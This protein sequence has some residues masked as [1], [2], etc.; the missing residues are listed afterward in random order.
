MTTAQETHE[1]APADPAVG[2]QLHRPV[3]RPVQKRAT[4]CEH[5]EPYFCGLCDAD[6]EQK[7]GRTCEHGNAWYCGWCGP[8]GVF[9]KIAAARA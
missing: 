5:G 9:A 7:A 8:L 6:A 4:L 2:I 3:G 1:N